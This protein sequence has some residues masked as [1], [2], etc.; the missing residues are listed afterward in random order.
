MAKLPRMIPAAQVP[1]L[2]HFLYTGDYSVDA[3]D[4][5]YYK[6]K[7]CPSGC[8]T[9]TQI[10]KLLRV[11]LA[12][13]RTALLLGIVELQA[14]AFSRFRALLDT[15]P[16]WVLQ[17][18]VQVVYSRDPIPDGCNDF[19]V[20]AVKGLKDY[21]PELVLPAVLRWCGYYRM[22]PKN[23]FGEQEFS[24]LR[25]ACSAFNTHLTFGLWLDTVHITV[26]R[27]KFPGSSE[28]LICIHPYLRTPLPKMVVDRNRSNYQYVTY[29]QPLPFEDFKEQRPLNVPGYVPSPTSRSNSSAASQYSS[30]NASQIQNPVSSVSY[31]PMQQS[32]QP[33]QFNP[34]QVPD[35][36]HFDETAFDF[37][38]DPI[39][40]PLPRANF[41][42][43]VAMNTSNDLFDPTQ[44]D[45]SGADISGFDFDQ[46]LNDVSMAPQ[47]ANAFDWTQPINWDE[48]PVADTNFTD[49]LNEDTMDMNFVDPQGNDI[50][51]SDPNYLNLPD[52]EFTGLAVLGSLKP[53]VRAPEEITPAPDTTGFNSFDFMLQDYPHRSATIRNAPFDWSKAIASPINTTEIGPPESIEV[54]SP[55][56]SRYDLRSQ[57]SIATTVSEYVPSTPYSENTSKKVSVA[58]TSKSSTPK[59]SISKKSRPS[60]KSRQSTIT[61]V[62]RSTVSSSQAIP[63]SDSVEPT[64]YN[65]RKRA[66]AQE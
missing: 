12:M 62:K 21:R 40:N 46:T 10:C 38:L 28:A 17:Y 16:A 19:H 5:D 34:S 47:N 14:I 42:A 1:S 66:P 65:L 11:H 44:V 25:Q 15:A 26:P 51:M 64:R 29:L 52:I 30:R 32:Y 9:C 2:L 37:N 7:P 49:Y 54:E 56:S 23:G 35:A 8:V 22:H 3:K 4:M 53:P 33:V 45:F 41:M 48:A 6:A 39:T 18:A 57:S 58:S 31:I 36:G 50:N 59:A 20:S 60:P 24:R 61:P 13:F 63:K 55:A 27:L 43:P